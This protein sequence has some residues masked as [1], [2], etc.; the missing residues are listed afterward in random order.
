[1]NP[2]PASPAGNRLPV[3]GWRF[4]VFLLAT[5]LAI[6]GMAAWWAANSLLASRRE[7]ENRAAILTQNTAK[8]IDQAIAAS[9]EKIDLTLRFL[10]DDLEGQLAARGHVDPRRLKDLAERYQV[11]VPEVAVL[12]ATDEA[13]R[14]FRAS[15][16]KEPPINIG[17][18]NHFLTH[19]SNP[20]AGLTVSAPVVGRST[21]VWQINFTRR[22][23]HSDGSFAG[24]VSA[25]V[26]LSHF[27]TLLA[28]PD[29]GPHGIALLRYPDGGLL[30]RHPP[31]PDD[32]GQVGAKGYSPELAAAIA[33]GERTVTYHSKQTAD[34]T[35]RTNT[36]RRIQGVPFFLVI[37]AGTEDYLADWLTER[38]NMILFGSAF[39]TMT[40][41]MAALIWRLVV[42][43]AKTGE[44]LTRSNSEL[45]AALEALEQRNAEIARFTEVL[46]HHLQEPVRLQH[47]FAQR[48]QHLLPEPLPPELDRALGFIKSGALRQR[49]LL[50]DVEHYLALAQQP[51]GA[52]QPCN[53][54]EALA[55]ACRQ[56]RD[57]IAATGATIQF[58][59]L[60][61]VTIPPEHLVELFTEIIAN[62]LEYRRDDALPDIRVTGRI[63]NGEALIAVADNGIGIPEEFRR[64]A[65]GVFERVGPRTQADGTG[66]G[67]ALA[68]RI[69]QAAKGSIWIETSEMGGTTVMWTL[70][71]A[72]QPAGF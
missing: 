8:A 57:R 68:K 31:V 41:L 53:V 3:L 60:P 56:L 4:G 14:V 52:A 20:N 21:K 65:F 40:A 5:V 72:D 62:A 33:S 1:M 13:G 29:L 32:S 6:D 48:L 18:R 2:A 66:I 28:A 25:V 12:V 36:L 70:P 17:D 7:H 58:Q 39:C 43:Q 24:I 59:D 44:D 9:V 15:D 30:V 23:N 71:L 19:A 16:D 34:G 69:V 45:V 46:A 38:D 63:V 37:G 26:T 50:R 35:E 10:V 61:T 27:S 64:R 67:L 55:E 51:S 49:A 22:Y 42:R 11:R 47:A 54:E